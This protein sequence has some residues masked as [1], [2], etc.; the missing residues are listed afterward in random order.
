M[1]KRRT[2]RML[3]LE[4]GLVLLLI[5]LSVEFFWR[6]AAANFIGARWWQWVTLVALFFGILLLH[7]WRRRRHMHA[8]LHQA[9]REDASGMGD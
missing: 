9:I 1:A 4:L 2:D 3:L 8:G 6:S 5:G 7:Q